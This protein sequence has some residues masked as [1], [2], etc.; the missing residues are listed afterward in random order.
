MVACF[1]EP[2]RSLAPSGVGKM[3]SRTS[4]PPGA[5]GFTIL[6][7]RIQPR[8]GAGNIA[9]VDSWAG[10]CAVLSK[11]MAKPAGCS[12]GPEYRTGYANGAAPYQSCGHREGHWQVV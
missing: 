10:A 12:Q 5:A 2:L 1:S 3:L 8:D 4:A 6:S 11:Y 7:L 9:V